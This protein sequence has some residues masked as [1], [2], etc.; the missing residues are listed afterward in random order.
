MS[1]GISISRSGWYVAADIELGSQSNA[2]HKT[3]FGKWYFFRMILPR[4]RFESQD[5]GRRVKSNFWSKQFQHEYNTNPSRD[6]VCYKSFNFYQN[7]E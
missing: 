7:T 1:F 5:E 3:V 4:R 2:A 6:M